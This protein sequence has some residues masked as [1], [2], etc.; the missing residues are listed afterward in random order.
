[1]CCIKYQSLFFV[2]LLHL[3]YLLL[4]L[5]QVE[6][7]PVNKRMEKFQANDATTIAASLTD[8]VAIRCVKKIA[9]SGVPS[10]EGGLNLE[11]TPSTV[12]DSLN[13]LSEDLNSQS[14]QTLAPVSSTPDTDLPM[15]SPSRNVLPVSAITLMAKTTQ[16]EPILSG[17]SCTGEIA[18]N[19]T[20]GHSVVPNIVP[21]FS[22][23]LFSTYS[24]SNNFVATPMSS[25]ACAASGDEKN[26]IT[27]TPAVGDQQ[28]YIIAPQFN[29]L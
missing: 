28:T 18:T 13:S 14:S 9:I 24:L 1:M 19:Y 2:C 8:P 16:L 25:V 27:L 26:F 11:E 22:L 20:S 12:N 4:C 6:Y 21:I 5:Q 29:T 3:K 7:P 17:A 10:S 15:S 23:P